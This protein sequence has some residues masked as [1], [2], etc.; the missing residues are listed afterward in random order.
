MNLILS[1]YN[2]K[3]IFN[4]YLVPNNNISN[5]N[6]NEKTNGGKVYIKGRFLVYPKQEDRLKHCEILAKTEHEIAKCKVKS[7]KIIFEIFFE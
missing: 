2:L 3:F 5:K 7:I 1:F 4:N 6:I